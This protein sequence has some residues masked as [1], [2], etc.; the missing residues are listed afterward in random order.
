M[1]QRDNDGL[2][3]LLRRNGRVVILVLDVVASLY[4]RRRF[5]RTM[6]CHAADGMKQR[7]PLLAIDLFGRFGLKGGFRLSDQKMR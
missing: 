4:L 5:L 7:L 1:S 2:A 6:T 3:R